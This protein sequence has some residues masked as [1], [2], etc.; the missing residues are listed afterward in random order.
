MNIRLFVSVLAF[1]TWLY[2]ASVY[3]IWVW[4][5]A[6][7][8]SFAAGWWLAKGRLLSERSAY[9]KCFALPLALTIF[10]LV[11]SLQMPDPNFG[12]IVGELAIL[13]F[14][15]AL[16]AFAFVRHILQPAGTV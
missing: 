11:R 2:V 9:V 15:A 13:H 5:L 12:P 4:Q 14:V 10:L 1:V 16:A 7:G 8:I 6:A 3:L